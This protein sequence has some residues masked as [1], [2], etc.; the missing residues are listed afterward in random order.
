V[1]ERENISVA[2]RWGVSGLLIGAVLFAALATGAARPQDLAVSQG[3]VA[4]ALVLWLAGLILERPRR[5]FLPPPVWAALLVL[6]YVGVWYTQSLLEYTGRREAVYMLLLGVVFWLGVQQWKD[7]DAARQLAYSLVLVGALIAGYGIFQFA[8]GWERVWHFTRPEQY[9]GRA[10]GTFICP[11]HYAAFLGMTFPL[12]LSYAFLGRGKVV[13][14]LLLGY[15]ALL[16]LAGIAVS[17]SRGAWVAAALTLLFM[18]GVLARQRGVRILAVLLVVAVGVGA[19]FFLQQSSLARDRFS[20]ERSATRPHEMR[21]RLWIWQSAG[22]MWRE[23]P[24]IGV[25]PGHFDHRFPAYRVR[26]AQN[27][28]GRVHNDYLNVLV[29][30]GVVGAVLGLSFLGLLAVGGVRTWKYVRRGGSD[31]QA[32]RSDRA[33]LVLGAGGGLVFFGI[34]SFAEF[35][36]YVPA[37]GL[38]AATL[39]GGL[40][41][42]WRY[43]TSRHWFRLGWARLSLL[44]LAGLGATVVFLGQ[45]LLMA[46]EGRWLTAAEASRLRDEQRLPLLQRA[47]EIEPRNYETHFALGEAHRR[48]SW[49]GNP[50]WEEAAREAMLWF[51]SADALNVH[52]PYAPLHLGMCLDW[53]GHPALGGPWIEEALRRDPLN[54]YAVAIRG[55]HALQRNELLEAQAWFRRSME[56][57]I[58]PNNISRRHLALIERR[59]REAGKPAAP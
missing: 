54:Y 38:L 46:R 17:L 42:H 34:H 7:P 19:A 55:W 5:I 32:T 33:G 12:A 28:P 10:S 52:S 2:L 50:G 23:H 47:L 58:W 25:G 13:A 6:V 3:L 44:S 36:L 57:K 45:G 31:L 49:R 11:N 9:A 27:R 43:A 22:N 30:Y 20:Y 16:L 29:D 24:W 15:A 56:I 48:I 40:A 39:A 59:L 1:P 53:L 18:L 51:R 4:L 21:T 35:N 14:R 26:L 37:T 41:S 8:A